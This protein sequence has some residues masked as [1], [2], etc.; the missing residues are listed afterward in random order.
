VQAFIVICVSVAAQ[1]VVAFVRAEF[2]LPGFSYS[3]VWGCGFGNSEDRHGLSPV[4]PA[5]GYSSCKWLEQMKK[6]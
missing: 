6:S 3:S 1:A 2:I 5:L 4:S